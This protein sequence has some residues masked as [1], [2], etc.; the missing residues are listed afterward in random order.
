MSWCAT[1][2]QSNVPSNVHLLIRL[3]F[4]CRYVIPDVIVRHF[5]DEYERHNSFRG[6]C[7]VGFRW[8]DIENAHLRE[9]LGVRIQH[10][11]QNQIKS[12]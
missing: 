9:S 6:C 10:I 11:N 3:I 7:S 5:L 12:K 2:C 1:Y 8:Q 4:T